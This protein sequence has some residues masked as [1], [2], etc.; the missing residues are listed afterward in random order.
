MARGGGGT[1]R[2]SLQPPLTPAQH[3]SMDGIFVAGPRAVFG[4]ATLPN[5]GKGTENQDTYVTT[6]SHSGTKCFVG[7][8]DGHG[9][10][11][12]R[13]SNVA[14]DVLSK[15]LFDHRDLHSDPKGALE[16]AYR[17]AQKQIEKRHGPEAQDS[18][19]TAVSAYQHRDRLFVANVGDSRAVLGRCD[20][21]RGG[22]LSAVEL[23]RD[24]K[25]SRADERQRIIAAGG[26]VEQGI[27]PVS[28][29]P[30]GTVRWMRGGPERVMSRNGL[31]GLAVSRSLGD[32]SLR[33]FVS[34]QPEV[35]ERKLDPKDKFIVLGSD[36][37]WDQVSSKEAVDIVGRHADPST[38]A[39]EITGVAR[40][41]WKMQTGG[42][43]ADDI[44]AVVMKLD[45]SSPPLTL[46]SIQVGHSRDGSVG[47]RTQKNQQGGSSSSSPL[48][49]DYGGSGYL[50]NTLDSRRPKSHNVRRGSE[51]PGLAPRPV[52]AVECH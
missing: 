2:Q 49:P 37:I 7:V 12:G 27:F 45:N 21:S 22:T 40:K 43:L 13:I 20:T 47:G 4:G 9:E 11:G 29:G 6:A 50:Q 32:L 35:V 10:Q 30:G 34:A 38:A 52:V 24:H 19:T 44:T 16:S 51:P 28:V 1:H 48:R 25:P 15:S 3:R 31:G 8:F 23:S 26:K 36:G 46:G 18:G 14:R 42:Q 17:E 5:M 33:P 41:R 39:Q